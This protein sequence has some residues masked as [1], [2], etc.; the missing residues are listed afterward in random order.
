MSWN[1]VYLLP[2]LEIIGVNVVLSGDNAVLVA[3]AVHRLPP[4]QRR[5]ALA[6]GAAGA[7]VLH[8]ATTLVVTQLLRIPLLLCAGGLL[9]AWIALKLLQEEHEEAPRVHAA[10]NLGHAVR[11]I[12]AADFIMSLDNMLA[13]AGVG[14]GHPGLIVFGLLFSVSLI[15]RGSL[16]ISTLMNRYPFFV[17][18]GAGILAWTA[19]HM[20]ATDTVIDHAVWAHWGVD[21]KNGFS[22]RRS[23]PSSRC[24][25]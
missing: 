9:L 11:T 15:M 20:M 24:W 5:P 16:F 25:W 23:L 18:I 2:L 7:I 13:V 12:I 14:Q 3:M 1:A 10:E 17:T 6:L 4:R 21:L 19:G 22:V 8:I